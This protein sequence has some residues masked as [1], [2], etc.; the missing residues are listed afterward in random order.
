MA[1]LKRLKRPTEI[2]ARATIDFTWR[3][4][5]RIEHH[6]RS[7]D[8]VLVVRRQCALFLRNHD[9]TGDTDEESGLEHDLESARAGPLGSN[10]ST[11]YGC[12]RENH[13]SVQSSP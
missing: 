3:E 10:S 11:V 4:A 8:H 6:L 7:E 2:R 5:C 9:G 13:S 1:F 12:V